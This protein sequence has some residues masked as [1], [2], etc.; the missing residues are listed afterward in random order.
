MPNK[1][2]I[3]KNS[4]DMETDGTDE[5]GNHLD[6]F[7][8]EK[9]DKDDPQE[10][11]ISFQPWSH[12]FQTTISYMCTHSDKNRTGL[13]PLGISEICGFVF[14][15]NQVCPG[16]STVIGLRTGTYYSHAYI[17]VYYLPLLWHDW[18]Q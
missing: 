6:N 1:S 11:E 7:I 4:Q 17:W 15:S 2:P 10:G 5:L 3:S 18:Y 9:E 16:G 12:Y 13:S 14:T 8:K